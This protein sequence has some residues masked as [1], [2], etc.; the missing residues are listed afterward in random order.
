MK[1]AKSLI[2]VLVSIGMLALV[3]HLV[4]FQRLGQT[5]SE[6]SIWTFSLIILG[7]ALGQLLS[8]WKWSLIAASGGIHSTFPVTL[9]AYLIGMYANC[10]GLGLVGGDVLR[11]LLLAGKTEN[12]TTALAS[13][14]AD[15][16]H[17][18]AVLVVLG[19]LFALFDGRDTISP[20]FIYFTLLIPISVLALWIVGPAVF[21]KLLPPH[22]RLRHKLEQAFSAFPKDIGTVVSITVISVVFHLSQLF[23]H[24]VI[25][26]ALGASIPL[27]YVLSSIPFVN[28]LASL[29]ISWNGLGVRENSYLFFLASV[30][31]TNEQAVA[32]GA[33][34]LIAVAANSAIGGI[35]AFVG[36]DLKSEVERQEKLAVND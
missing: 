8:A 13:V 35:V 25:F 18:L 10:F 3:L 20:D 36:G 5:L 7:Y 4:D 17:G 33:I 29:P 31:L 15:R 11:G 1:T 19:M 14:V 21:F 30:G 28:V 9:R 34:W 16:A 22:N 27:L 24:F 26:R 23:L 12:K 2:K 32:T 6:I